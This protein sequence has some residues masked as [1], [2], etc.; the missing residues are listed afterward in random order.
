LDES[1]NDGSG[2]EVEYGD[3]NGV[4]VGVRFVEN[5]LGKIQEISF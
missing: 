5:I 3:E 1:E 2:T 4:V